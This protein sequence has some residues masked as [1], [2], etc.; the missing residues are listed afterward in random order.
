MFEGDFADTCVSACAARVAL[1]TE[2]KD[3]PWRVP[4]FFLFMI[5]FKVFCDL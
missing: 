3:A 4:V 2:S 1:Q 5:H